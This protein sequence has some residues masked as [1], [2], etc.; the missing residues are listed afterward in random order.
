MVLK[1][2]SG[3]RCSG[4]NGNLSNVFV[5]YQGTMYLWTWVSSH[6][7]GWHTWVIPVTLDASTAT[8]DSAGSAV[9]PHITHLRFIK[10]LSLPHCNPE[11]IS[12]L[13]AFYVNSLTLTFLFLDSQ[14][15]PWVSL[16][17]EYMKLLI[18]FSGDPLQY[19]Q[20][21]L[22]SYFTLVHWVELIT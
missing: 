20:E 9:S 13:S 6:H 19:M 2:L 7:S 10:P 21:R 5:V 22:Q 18:W 17:L 8:S 4:D 14:S 11:F 1:L 16:M 3:C 12:I 15:K